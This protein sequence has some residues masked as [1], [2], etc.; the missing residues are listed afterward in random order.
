[1]VMLRLLFQVRY[2][3]VSNL[4]AT[5]IVPQKKLIQKKLCR[6]LIISQ[7]YT[8]AVTVSEMPVSVL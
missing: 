7:L 3:K 6:K 8:K 2:L 5:K 4:D 1:M